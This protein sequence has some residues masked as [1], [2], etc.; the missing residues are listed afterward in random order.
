MST[1]LYQPPATPDI[2]NPWSPG[3]PDP[4]LWRLVRVRRP[5]RHH[6][7]SEGGAGPPGGVAWSRSCRGQGRATCAPRTVPDA[8]R[9][10]GR[11]HVNGESSSVLRQT[12]T[13]SMRRALARPIAGTRE[14]GGVQSGPTA[15]PSAVGAPLES[16]DLARSRCAE[17]RLLHTDS[18]SRR[19][20]R[21]PQLGG[22]PAG[23]P[24]PT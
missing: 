17:A 9:P 3:R 1:V 14:S 11:P 18:R 21:A 6:T 10:A 15:S 2:D 22:S 13:G 5:H 4:R 19:Y 23:A 12:V 16:R 24:L 20:P 7:T 8:R